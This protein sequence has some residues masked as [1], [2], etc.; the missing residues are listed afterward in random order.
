MAWTAGGRA[1]LWRAIASGSHGH[2]EDG[3]EPRHDG[4]DAVR[5]DGQV[6]AR[7]VLLEGQ[8]VHVLGAEQVGVEGEGAVVED[9]VEE[10]A[11]L[12][13][14]GPGQERRGTYR[15]SRCGRTRRTASAAG[16]AGCAGSGSPR[17]RAP[18]MACRR[19]ALTVVSR[20]PGVVVKESDS[21]ER[22]TASIR[23][24][25]S[26]AAKCR[27]RRLLRPRLPSRGSAGPCRTSGGPR[28][29][30]PR[31]DRSSRRCCRSPRRGAAGPDGRRRS[32]VAARWRATWAGRRAGSGARSPADRREVVEV[33]Q[34]I[35]GVV[36]EM[37]DP[38]LDEVLA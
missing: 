9:V 3:A 37:A 26:A 14:V 10:A 6:V 27:A 23:G 11:V 17:C 1:S 22:P 31:P 18:K 38:P 4:G 15:R 19:R 21:L 24:S 2:A 33:A 32:R 36:D 25:V 5:A 35:E 30:V 16:R 13:D 12:V 8:D 29:R 20:W 34:Q 7:P 28:R